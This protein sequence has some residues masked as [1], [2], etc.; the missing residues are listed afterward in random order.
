MLASLY[1][2]LNED[3]KQL[4]VVFLSGDKTDEEFDEYFSEMP[5]LALPRSQK[6]VVMKIAKRFKI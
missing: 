1:E 2:E 4:E 5:W 3:E 6:S